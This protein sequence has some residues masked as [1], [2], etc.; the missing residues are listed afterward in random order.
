MRIARRRFNFLLINSLSSK[1]LFPFGQLVFQI[2][3]RRTPDTSG[4]SDDGDGSVDGRSVATS[5][6]GSKPPTRAK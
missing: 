1:K 3:G 6:R 5:A 2:K 4:Q